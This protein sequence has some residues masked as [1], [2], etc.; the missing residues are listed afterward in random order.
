MRHVRHALSLSVVAALSACGP[1]TET[2]RDPSI[3]TT[4]ATQTAAAAAGWRSQVLYLVMPD[5]FR[6]GDTSNDDAGSPQCHDASDPQRFHGGDLEGLRKN[7]AYVRELGATAVWVT[8]LYRQIA[9][10]PNGHCGYHGYWADYVEPYDDAL[11]PKLGTAAD[12]HALV[13]DMHAS[14]MR[15]VLDMVVNH[16]GDTAR[17]PKQRPAWF[18]DPRTCHGL[19]DAMVFC[20]L[21]GHPDFAQE[22]GD[23][24]AYLSDVAARWTSKHGIDGIRMDTAKHV[25]PAYFSSSFFPA[26]R[27]ARAD[28]FAVAEAFDDGSIDPAARYVNAGFDSAFHFPLRR[29][30]VDA[31]GKSGSVDRVASAVAAGIAKLGMDR[32]L[33][34]VVFADNHDVPRFA[35][36]PGWGVP[37]DEV[38]RRTMLAL[39]LVFTLPGIPQLYQGDELG[40]YGGGDPDNRRDLPSWATSAAGRA[41]AHPGEAVAGSAQVFARVQK[42]AALRTSVPALVD[43]AYRELWRQNGA[44]NP[45]VFAFARGTGDAARVV[46]ISNGAARSGTMRIPVPATVFPD[47]AQLVDELGDGAPASV[48]LSGGKL[49]VDLPPRSAAIYRRVTR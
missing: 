44:Q 19:G 3:E 38:R 10:L 6:N 21:D 12:L 24:A 34:L 45:N 25:P 17:L 4:T 26:V 22:R 40:M 31:I 33:D 29:A 7:L 11:E 32:A 41:A 9:R 23:V 42:L 2:D 13:A 1:S 48:T 28:L 46:V 47:G 37:D 35:N 5:R 27:G 20:P 14:N 49:V 43:G 16:T 8:P 18:H 36:E 30:L 15:L 39:A